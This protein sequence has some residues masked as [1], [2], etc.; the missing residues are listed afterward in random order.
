MASLWQKKASVAQFLVSIQFVFL[1]SSLCT[2]I[3]VVDHFYSF[4][5]LLKEIPLKIHVPTGFEENRMQL[6]KVALVTKLS[7]AKHQ[8]HKSKANTSLRT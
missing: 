2:F 1:L 5:F 6:S 3:Y 4:R 8:I 7:F